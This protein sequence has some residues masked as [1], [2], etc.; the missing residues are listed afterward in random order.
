MLRNHRSTDPYNEAMAYTVDRGGGTF[1]AE[2]CIPFEP[3]AGYA[4]AVGGV[5]LDPAITGSFRFRNAWKHVASEFMTLFVG[6][7]LDGDNLYVDA[8]RYFGPEWRDE[9]IALGREHNQLAIYDFAA[10]ESI[11]LVD[12]EA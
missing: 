1:H 8:V 3:I 2:T 5:I 12:P 4:V 6:T 11:T 7:W 9:A 10:G